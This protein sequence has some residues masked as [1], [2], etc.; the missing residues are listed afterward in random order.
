VETGKIKILRIIAFLFPV[1]IILYS[2]FKQNTDWVENIY[3]KLIFN[4]LTYFL[5]TITSYFEVSIGL[6]FIYFIIFF[7]AYKFIKICIDLFKKKND[8]KSFSLKLFS[9]LSI[10]Y[11]FYMLTWGLAYYRKPI[12]EINHLNIENVDFEEIKLLAEKLIVLT[13]EKRSQIS[14]TQARSENIEQYFGIAKDGYDNISEKIP[15]LSYKKPSLKI[16]FNKT[17]LSYLSTGGIYSFPS[18]E[19]NINANN[20]AFEAPFTI[21]HEMAHQLG[22][23]SEEEANYI[24]FLAC[25]NNPKPIFQYSAYAEALN[26]TLSNI[27]RQDTTLYLKM[28]SKVDTNV[29]NDFAFA[30]AKW[31]NYQIPIIR[32]VSSTFYDL[33]LK[34]NNQ[35]E[36]IKSYGLV[37]ELLVG[38]MRKNKYFL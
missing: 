8:F 5:R 29:L 20:T 34:S 17:I 24:S 4:K 23:A 33:F 35:D 27:Y 11:G 10:L 19:A 30:R 2:W 14:N 15:E 1:Q 28:K 38:E 26:Y 3:I 13:N 32:S 12:A 31:K 18:G 16:G 9:T 37:V 22:F 21:C 7:L 25:T 36:G 6:I